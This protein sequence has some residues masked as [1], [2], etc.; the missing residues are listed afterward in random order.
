MNDFT[1]FTQGLVKE[2]LETG[3]DLL[4]YSKDYELGMQSPHLSCAYCGKTPNTIQDTE[5]VLKYGFCLGCEDIHND[6]VNDAKW[7]AGL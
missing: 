4:N 1:K 5:Y 7:E 3:R 2:K 6:Y